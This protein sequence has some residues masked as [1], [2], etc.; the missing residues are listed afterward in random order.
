MTK[1]KKR[2]YFL[3]SITKK[4]R[5]SFK[6]YCEERQISMTDKIN[7]MIDKVINWKE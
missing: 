6:K 7:R 1:T 3:L 4:K 5:N 2:N